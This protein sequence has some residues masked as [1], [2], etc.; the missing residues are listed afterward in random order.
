MNK[1]WAMVIKSGGRTEPVAG[2]IVP[3]IGVIGKPQ[4][5]VI[6]RPDFG[7]IGLV[8]ESG[9]VKWNGANSYGVQ[10]KHEPSIFF[11]CW[12]MDRTSLHFIPEE[13]KDNESHLKIIKAIYGIHNNEET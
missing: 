5:P 1:Q 8:D 12:G 6:I 10:Q 13:L 3:V 7:W 11:N 4:K 9:N 2:I